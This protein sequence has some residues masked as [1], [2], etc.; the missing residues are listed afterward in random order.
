MLAVKISQR[1]SDYVQ[2]II[3]ASVKVEAIKTDNTREIGAGFFVS[4]NIIVTCAHVLGF[5]EQNPNPQI[6]QVVITTQDEARLPAKVIDYDPQLD[7]AVLYVEPQN[8]V[9][10]FFLNLGN[11]GTIK[12]GEIVVTLGSPL[13]YTNSASYGIVSKRYANNNNYFLLDMRTNPGNSG[14]LVYSVDKQAVI[15]V[16]VAV[17]NAADMQSEGISVG[18]AIDAI[19]NMLKKNGVKFTY[20]EKTE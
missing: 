17:Y 12:E 10:T 5:T 15:G 14:G 1:I 13:G 20:H 11:S 4:P 3:R 9:K 7:I 19:K 6:S 16:C 8:S 18:I 2:Q